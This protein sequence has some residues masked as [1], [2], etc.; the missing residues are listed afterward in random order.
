MSS[1]LPIEQKV[2]KCPHCNI[3]VRF[4]HA[5][6]FNYGP[7]V[8]KNVEY[9]QTINGIKCPECNKLIVCLCSRDHN[10]LNKKPLKM[11]YPLGS[12]RPPVP[13][14]VPEPITQDYKEACLI[15][16]LSKKAA[17][18]LARRCLQNLLRDP[19][20]GNVK[21]GNLSKE[22]DQVIPKL[23]SALAESIDTIRQVGNW[24]AHPEKYKNTGE[25]VDVEPQEAEWSLNAL[26]ELFDHYYVKPQRIKHQRDELN[27]KLQEM[28][29]PPL[30]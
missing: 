7:L 20:A 16:P 19:N 23:P 29:K 17:A 27:K 3:S 6:E 11:L 1:Q 26:E 4:E 28:G 14:T 30:K 13:P 8:Q 10:K 2:G 9:Y 22:I 5:G 21:R 24:G 25:I 12:A 15:E 18:A